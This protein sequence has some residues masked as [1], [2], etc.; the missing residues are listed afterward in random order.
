MAARRVRPA[1]IGDGQ[2]SALIRIVPA[3]QRPKQVVLGAAV[4]WWR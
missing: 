3:G 2:H 4:V 1:V